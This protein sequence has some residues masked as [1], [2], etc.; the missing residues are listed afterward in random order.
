MFMCMF[1]SEVCTAASHQAQRRG[2]ERTPLAE[3]GERALIYYR[4]LYAF[5]SG[6]GRHRT[7]LMTTHALLNAE[8]P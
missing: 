6:E 8:Q 3:P 5:T 1:A 7:E 4:S 2:A